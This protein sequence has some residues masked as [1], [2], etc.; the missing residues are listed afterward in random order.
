MIRVAIVEDQDAAAETLIEFLKR[1]EASADDTFH[2]TRFRDALS[3]LSPY[4]GFDL[5]FMDIQMPNLDGLSG[6][7]RLR[8]IDSSVTLIFVT[9]MAQYALRG[10]EV[11]ALDFI[12]KP[13]VYPDFAFKMKRALRSVSLSERKQ[14]TIQPPNGMVLLGVDEVEYVEVQGHNLTYH[15]A[16]RTIQV[17]GTMK[18]AEEQLCPHGFLRCNSCYLINPKHIKW[19]REFVVKVGNTELQ[20]SHP[21]K[22]QFM[23]S[24]SQ[25]F[26]KGGL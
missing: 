4:L 24:L 16:D 21:R 3:F 5:V 15:T 8:K 22:K 2:V 19:V 6:A 26:T 17:R 7:A 25:W 10:Y 11:D 13:I 12:V 1:F 9:N 14:L 20:I 18:N 23:E